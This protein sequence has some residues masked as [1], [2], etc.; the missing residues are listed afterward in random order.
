VERRRSGGLV[1]ALGVLALVAVA[2]VAWSGVLGGRSETSGGV[3]QEATAAL[4]QPTAPAATVP[5]VAPRTAVPPVAID[6]VA[7]VER[8]APA[9]V[10]VNN[11]QQA[12]GGL[13]GG[14][15]DPERAG[16]G[17]GFVLDDQGYVVTNEH[18]V[19]GGEEFEVIFA[20]GEER[21]AELI[22]ADPLADLAVVRVEGTLPAIIALGDSDALRVGEPVLA[23]GS[24]LG[25]FTNTVTQGI[26]SALNRDFPL[27]SRC[28][29]IYTNLI[30]HDAA[31]NP[32]NSGGPLFNAAGE[33]VGVNTLGIPD[34]QGLFFAVPAST[35]REITTEIIEDGQV[36][37]PL[38][39]VTGGAVTED[40]AAA[41]DLPVDYGQ[42]VQEVEPD[43]P[44]AEAGIETGDIVLTIDGQRIDQRNPFTEALFAHEPG[45][46]VEVTVRR[47]DEEF[48][49]QVTLDR[50]EQLLPEECFTENLMP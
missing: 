39:G 13:F 22:G 29:G 7:V 8:V 6:A 9:V 48:A 27:T 40:V 10:T 17:T 5:T 20:D 30:Q 49:A 3:V 37:Y 38:F 32:G 33:V 21:P 15:G 31:I 28:S 41:E 42:F 19:R 24:P 50:R 46:T 12:G 23:V 1:G 18:V 26:V 25:E 14:G 45:E 36:D 34:A 47:G 16:T 35:V 11:L 4:A 2:V 44:A 43:G